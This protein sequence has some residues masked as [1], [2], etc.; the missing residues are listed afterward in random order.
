[1]NWGQE[2]GDSTVPVNGFFCCCFTEVLLQEGP[3]LQTAF[4]VLLSCLTLVVC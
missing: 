1:M 4:L 2:I 3:H